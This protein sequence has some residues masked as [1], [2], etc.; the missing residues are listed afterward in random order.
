MRLL[1][2]GATGRLG[3]RVVQEALE[4]GHLVTAVARSPHALGL[5]HPNLSIEA[6]D[7]R[8]ATSLAAVM[9]NHE[10]VI[11]ALGYR[12]TQES[13][14]VLAQG[15]SNL[16]SAMSGSGV[17]R[18][19][20]CGAAGILQW[21]DVRLRCERPEYPEAFRAGASMHRR[22]WEMLKASALDWTLVCPP[23][24][25]SGDRLQPLSVQGEYLPDGPRRVSMESLAGW[26]VEELVARQW[27]HRRV[28]VCNAT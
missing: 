2:V 7:V 20:V 4:H 9:P 19:I 21:D 1:V 12:R 28:G 13:A 14:E 3:S 15:V 5:E 16:I 27:S 10:A 11:S 22:A 17:A 25:V 6:L 24:L 23:E 8:D 26:M 18:L